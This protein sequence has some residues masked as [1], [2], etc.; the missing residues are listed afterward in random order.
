MR[1]RLT[2]AAKDYV[3]KAAQQMGEEVITAMI[4]ETPYATILE[5]PDWSNEGLADLLVLL[6]GE[7]HIIWDFDAKLATKLGGAA[8]MIYTTMGKPFEPAPRDESDI[9]Q[10]IVWSNKQGIYT[11][12]VR[13]P[14]IETEGQAWLA[15]SAIG[16]AVS[17][18]DHEEEFV[19]DYGEVIRSLEPLTEEDFEM[20]KEAIGDKLAERF[21]VTGG[22]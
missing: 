10:Y 8:F 19:E 1:F 7:G 18:E 11:A 17:P 2:E 5:R 20:A 16:E 15:L 14:L 12:I 4:A 6:V 9:L 3:R 21:E 13:A 22:E